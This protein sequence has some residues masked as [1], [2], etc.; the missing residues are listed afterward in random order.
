MVYLH[1]KLLNDASF[2]PEGDAKAISDAIV[3]ASRTELSSWCKS[4]GK[5]LKA[6]KLDQMEIEFFCI[7][8]PSADGFRAAFLKAMGIKE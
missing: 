3:D 2:Y 7:P 4:I 6:E 8:L 1:R 5:R